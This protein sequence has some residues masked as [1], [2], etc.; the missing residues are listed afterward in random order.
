MKDLAIIYLTQEPRTM[1]S[2]KAVTEQLEEIIKIYKREFHHEWQRVFMET[3]TIHLP[4]DPADS[5]A[6]AALGGDRSRS[7][8]DPQ[9]TY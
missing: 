2:E 9:P 5:L 1:Q 8:S 3:M 4:L 6:A 7:L